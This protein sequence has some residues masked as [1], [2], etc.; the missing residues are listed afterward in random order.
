MPRTESMNFQ[1]HYFLHHEHVHPLG[2]GIFWFQHRAKIKSHF[3][4][5]SIEF[6]RCALYEAFVQNVCKSMSFSNG[7]ESESLRDLG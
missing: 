3:C 5:V 6:A 4:I 2:A 1:K 7:E